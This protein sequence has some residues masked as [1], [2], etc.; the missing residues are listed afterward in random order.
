MRHRSEIK[1]NHPIP[2][3][4]TGPQIFIRQ[5]VTAVIIL[6]VVIWSLAI[7]SM[8]FKANCL[9]YDRRFMIQ[10]INVAG[11]DTN[12][13]IYYTNSI[14]ISHGMLHFTDEDGVDVELIDDGVL[15]T[16]LPSYH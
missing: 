5:I 3:E 11:H 14:S 2:E 1:Q 9:Q 4:Y 6:L 16:T 15:I 8:Q 10:A 13:D 7:F 12:I